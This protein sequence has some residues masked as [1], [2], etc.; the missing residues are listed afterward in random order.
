MHIASCIMHLPER[1]YTW[2]LAVGLCCELRLSVAGL[3]VLGQVLHMCCPQAES[4]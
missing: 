4:T 2:K 3:V 1:P